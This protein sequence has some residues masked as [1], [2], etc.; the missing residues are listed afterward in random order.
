MIKQRRVPQGTLVPTD[1]AALALGITPGGV[2]I[3]AHRGRLRQYGTPR[4]RLY[5]L[6][7]LVARQE[8]E[9]TE[10][11]ACPTITTSNPA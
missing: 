11:T 9:R 1:V 6:A 2:R 4:R 3:L 10:N 5:D 7:E 8:H